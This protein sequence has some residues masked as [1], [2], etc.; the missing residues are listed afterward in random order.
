MTASYQ[1]IQWNR[2]KR[3]YDLLVASGVGLFLAVFV[4]GGVVT[5]PTPGEVAVPILA[6]RALGLTGFAMLHA[7]LL[8]GPLAR[9]S[10]R[11]VPLL[12]N[13]RH[14]GVMFFFV[15]L[16]H[17]LIATGFYGGFGVLDP[18]TAVLGGY[19]PTQQLS[20]APFELLGFLALCIFFVM[21]ATSHDFWL[22]T[23]S[24]RVWK[25]L[26]MLVYVAYGL[27]VMHVMLGAAQ[28]E[29]G[30]VLPGLTIAGLLTIVGVHLLAG[31]RESARDGTDGAAS[32]EP[33]G[34]LDAG[35]LDEIPESR[36]AVLCPGT[37]ER[38]AVF[39]NGE[40]VSAVTSVCAHQGGPLGEGKIVDGCITCPWHGYQYR[41]ED[42][43]SPPPYTEK[44]ATYDV[45]IVAGRALVNPEPNAP[46]TRGEPARSTGTT[47]SSSE[48]AS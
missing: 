45:R 20:S 36:A 27:V 3:V 40:A 13:R 46:G 48:E 32:E 47:T 12:Y 7:I 23:L 35:P 24:P 14:L 22:A 18:L 25:S 41:P 29:F 43:T 15:A 17:G 10:T 11:F 33:S 21:A 1:A 28:T 37:G 34:W 8:I 16:L 42:G 9:L 2:H 44:V 30:I 38:I 31:F 19:R 39:R 4:I 5:H 26:H 6:M